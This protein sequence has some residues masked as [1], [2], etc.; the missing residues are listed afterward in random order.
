[1]TKPTPGLP[2]F[3]NRE[4]FFGADAFDPSGHL[5]PTAVLGAMQELGTGHLEAT[6]FGEAWLAE[7]GSFWVIVR[8]KMVIHSSPGVGYVQ[9]V[10]WRHSVSGLYWRRDYQLRDH[11]G[12]LC[13]SVVALWVLLD[14]QNRRVQRPSSY[15]LA[16]PEEPEHQALPVAPAKLTVGE[17][18]LLATRR[19]CYSDLDSNGHVHNSRYVEWLLD[20]L[21]TPLLLQQQVAAL[22]VDFR[23]EAFLGEEVQL[24]GAAL[25]ANPHLWSFVAYCQERLCYV[26][27]LQFS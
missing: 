19:V 4:L 22:Q 10:T 13:C 14:R 16:F 24:S 8:L 25:E 11:A 18:P 23:G 27:Q 26:A 7:Q 20:A 6:G 1:M 12:E 3:Y 15:P 21:P 2:A 9:G 5:K 17:L